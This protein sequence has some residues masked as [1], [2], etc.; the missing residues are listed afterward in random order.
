MNNLKAPKFALVVAVLASAVLVACGSD[1]EGTT[2][3]TE[4]TVSEITE[5]SMSVTEES[6]VETTTVDTN[7]MSVAD[8]CTKI[9]A[10]EGFYID[11]NTITEQQM[12]EQQTKYTEIIATLP[13][14]LPDEVRG[15]VEFLSSWIDQSIEYFASLNWDNTAFSYDDWETK[16]GGSPFVME[17]VSWKNM[18]C[19]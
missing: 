1:S 7:L 5:S 11:L 4:P 19:T 16:T 6:S 9:S 18:N 17:L 2:S 12:L 13:S 8:F 10:L 15:D 3:E 14:E